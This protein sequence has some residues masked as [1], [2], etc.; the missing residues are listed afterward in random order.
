MNYFKFSKFAIV[1]MLSF[2]LAFIFIMFNVL[3]SVLIIPALVFLILGIV[4]IAVML[5]KRYKENKD[6]MEYKQEEIIMELAST[7]DGEKYIANNSSYIKRMK[8]SLK[9]QKWSAIY[10]I[11]L[12]LLLAGVFLGL[13]VKFIIGM[14]I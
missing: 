12:L 8:K 9:S 2:I 6:N 3:L 14:F 5:I 1:T 4:L 7:E 10:P 11:V 13:L